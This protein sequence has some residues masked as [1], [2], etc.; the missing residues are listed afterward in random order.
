MGACPPDQIEPMREVAAR[1]LPGGLSARWRDR[2]AVENRKN[3]YDER[4]QEGPALRPYVGT[5]H[6]IDHFA[7]HRK[8]QRKRLPAR[9]LNGLRK[10][11]FGKENLGVVARAGARIFVDSLLHK[12]SRLGVN[13]VRKRLPV[14]NRRAGAKQLCK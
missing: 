3:E 10:S 7:D 13:K 4:V 6:A 14:A 8:S 12:E 11:L 9:V 5:Q 2:I 1:F